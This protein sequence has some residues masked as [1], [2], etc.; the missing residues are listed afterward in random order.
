MFAWPGVY[1]EAEHHAVWQSS[2]G[3]LIDVSPPPPGERKILFVRDDTKIYD[4]ETHRRLDNQRQS[5]N[6]DLI[7]QQFI[8]ISSEMALFQEDHSIGRQII[9]PREKLIEIYMRWQSVY[10]RM[11][12]RY[13]SPNDLCTCNS[14][15]KIKRCC[16][17]DNAIRNVQRSPK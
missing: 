12:R 4:I 3:R 5:L 2:D 16:G 15:R 8:D 17:M 6:K 13:L 10:I 9:M 1:V 7:I 11:L 14:G